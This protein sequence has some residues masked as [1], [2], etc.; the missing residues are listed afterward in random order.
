[1]AASMKQEV[2][3]RLKKCKDLPSPPG[4]AAQIIELSSNV[5]SD[6]DTLAEVVSMD[7]VLSAKIIRMANSSLYMR[8][9]ETLDVQQAV[10]MFGWTGTLNIA[11]SFSV[12]GSIPK[13]SAAG[14]DHGLFWKRSLATAVACRK[15]GEVVQYPLREEL[16]LPGLLQDIGMLALDKA[17][18]KVYAGISERQQ[19]HKYLC[20][21][22][23]QKLGC[24]HAAA[25]EWLLKSWRIPEKITRLIAI[26]HGEYLDEYDDLDPKLVKCIRYSGPMADCIYCDEENKDYMDVANIAEKQFG[27]DITDFLSLIGKLTE[28]YQELA[29]LFDVDAGDPKLLQANAE[30]A[31]Q[32]LL[33]TMGVV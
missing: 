23:K 4:V 22:E 8:R 17:I 25:G 13:N 24:D 19:D 5:N 10:M 14:L 15:L 3:D 7:P 31:K 27:L 20:V 28:E 11:L 9:V 21:L 12:V 33:K 30:N 32:V 29:T 2:L 16:F 6:I 1:M 26:S 18:P